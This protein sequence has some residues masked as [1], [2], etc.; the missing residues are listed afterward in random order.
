MIARSRIRAFPA[1]FHGEAGKE[2]PSLRIPGE[3]T[4]RPLPMPGISTASRVHEEHGRLNPGEEGS[5][6]T[7]K[8]E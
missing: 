2:N 1:G 8:G 7:G 3:N 5:K 4:G 6:E